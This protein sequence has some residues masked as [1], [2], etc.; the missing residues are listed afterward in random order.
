ME[1]ENVCAQHEQQVFIVNYLYLPLPNFPNRE[2]ILEYGYRANGM[3]TNV[4]LI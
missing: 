3:K 2:Y 1:R 4:I